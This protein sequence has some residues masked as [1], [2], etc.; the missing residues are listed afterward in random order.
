MTVSRGLTAKQAL[1]LR[2]YMCPHLAAIAS[3]RT[4]CPIARLTLFA[5][6]QTAKC[7][8]M[9]PVLAAAIAS[10]TALMA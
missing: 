4:V 10:V 8:S 7:L 3:I 1:H 5:A 2:S 6:R 9:T